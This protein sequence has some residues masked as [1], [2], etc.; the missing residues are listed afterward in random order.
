MTEK[1]FCTVH[2]SFVN[3]FL[4]L[5]EIGHGGKRWYFLFLLDDYFDDAFFFDDQIQ[6][7]TAK[8][9]NLKWKKKKTPNGY[10]AVILKYVIK[11]VDLAGVGISSYSVGYRTLK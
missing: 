3:R 6:H 2:S 7:I 1:K 10:K 5:Y 9:P 8:L 4:D 11:F